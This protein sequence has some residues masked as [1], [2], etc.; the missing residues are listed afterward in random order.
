MRSR[1]IYSML[2]GDDTLAALVTAAKKQPVL[3]RE[4]EVELGRAIRDKKCQKARERLSATHIRLVISVASKMSGYGLPMDEIVAQGMIGLLKAVDRFDPEQENRFSTYAMWW[5]RAETV[6]Y[7][8]RNWSLVK[9]GTTASQKALFFRLKRAKDQLGIVHSS[10]LDNDEAE[11]VAKATGTT[12]AEV[13]EMNRRFAMGGDAS[14]NVSKADN[15]GDAGS[16]WLDQLESNDPNPFE[17]VAKSHRQN[18]LKNILRPAL[19]ALTE[20]ERYIIE[21][22]RMNDDVI[23]LEEL[24]QRYGVSRERI[25]QI[26]V[27]VLKK[28]GRHLKRVQSNMGIELQA[29]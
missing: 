16:E 28:L 24:G 20:R 26:E 4:E 5:I 11:A 25:R 12:A 14:L 7:T 15:D 2:S 19:E 17:Q 18:L 1:A 8:L 29:A 23:T 22:R 21:N 3:T 6:D 27:I 10:D 9:I 13:I